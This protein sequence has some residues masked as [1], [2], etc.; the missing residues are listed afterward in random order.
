MSGLGYWYMKCL[1]EDGPMYKYS[2]LLISE[3]YFVL[4]LLLKANI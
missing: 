3:C 4:H 1:E 2:Q